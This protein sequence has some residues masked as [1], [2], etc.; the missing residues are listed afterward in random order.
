MLQIIDLI[1]PFFIFLTFI[2]GLIS[3][4]PGVSS[5]VRTGFVNRQKKETG[6]RA[7]SNLE[8]SFANKQPF[9]GNHSQAVCIIFALRDAN[10]LPTSIPSP[11]G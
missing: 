6:R 9:K 1:F 10:N 5:T 8:T 4:L 7:S 3:R 11:G 2:P